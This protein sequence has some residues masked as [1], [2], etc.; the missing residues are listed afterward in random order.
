[1]ETK[2]CEPCD[3]SKYENKL[4]ECMICYDNNYEESKNLANK[5]DYYETNMQYITECCKKS[6]HY[7]CLVKWCKKNNSCPNCRNPDILNDI[8]R[9]QCILC[10]MLMKNMLSSIYNLPN[11]SDNFDIMIELTREIVSN[12][13]NNYH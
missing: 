5:K 10:L 11:N 1:M 6:C 12:S 9:E 13:H 8:G 3:L 4:D 7:S 2:T